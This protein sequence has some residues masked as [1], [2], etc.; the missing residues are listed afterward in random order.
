MIRSFALTFAAFMLR[1]QLPMLFALGM[2]YPQASNV[3]AWACWVPNLSVA[4]WLVRRVS[5]GDR[6]TDQTLRAST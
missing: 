3:I 2:D 1:L 4:E 5:G 6:P